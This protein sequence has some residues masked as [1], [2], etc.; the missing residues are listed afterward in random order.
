MELTPRQLEVLELK[1]KGL[2]QRE[3]AAELGVSRWA[4]RSRLEGAERKNHNDPAVQAAMEVA[5]TALV[6]N[7]LWV[8]TKGED[9]T[10]YSVQ[11]KPPRETDRDVMAEV[12]EAFQNIPKAP[13]IG[14]PESVNTDLMTMYPL[15]D[16][17]LGLRS[18][19][20]VSGED[21]DLEKA[22]T[23]LLRGAARLISKAP[24]S[25]KALLVNG[26][27]FTH[28]DDDENATPAS[29]HVLDV[30]SR[31]YTTITVG[32]ELI[33]L[34][35][36]MLLQKHETV[37]YISV[38]GNHDPKN[39]V[40]IMVGL[41]YRF[42]GHNRVKI[43]LNPIEFSVYVWGQTLIAVHHG[44]RRKEADLIM[45]FAAEYAAVWGAALH[46]YLFTGHYHSREAKRYPGMYWERMEP[47][48]P[49]DHYAAS[50]AYD[51]A[52]SMTCITF[53]RETG[54]EDRSRVK[55]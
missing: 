46:R 23:R 3:I 15:F 6:P 29:K 19:A 38:P 7:M 26:G 30:D 16:V 27:D 50:S 9:G 52:A 49:R 8:K 10:R 25:S 11:L 47:V 21:M 45:F 1:K 35:I 24:N 36:E 55:L 12:H 37:D 5:N 2:T 17:H 14:H 42:L 54:E 22:Q 53:H 18:L 33:A 39:W 40:S 48:C 32:V 31:N 51:Q 41:Y 20:S 44:H 28:A 34:F 13:K 43:E 4:V